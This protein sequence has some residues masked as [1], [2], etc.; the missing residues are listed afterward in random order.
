MT[1]TVNYRSARAPGERLDGGALRRS[2]VSLLCVLGVSCS[3]AAPPDASPDALENAPQRQDESFELPDTGPP[4]FAPGRGPRVGIDEAHHNYHTADGRYRAFAELLQRDGYRV[5]GFAHELT[6]ESL[7]GID[8][9]VISNAVSAE[10]EDDWS[11]PNHPAFSEAEVAAAGA[12]V[13]AGGSL[14]LIADHMPM[15]GATASLARAFGVLFHDGF[16]YNADD[17]GLMTFAKEDGRL[18]EHGVTHDIPAVMTFTGQ[19]FLLAPGTDGEPLMLLEPGSY[20]LLPPVAWE[21]DDSTPRIPAD[22]MIQGA[23]LRHGS[24]RVAVFGEAAAFSAQLG[25]GSSTPMGMNSPDAPYNARFL[26]NVMRWLT[27][28]ENP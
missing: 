25:S 11:L 10:N 16:A 12:W 22:G 26:L 20:V 2:L 13:H 3:G 8:V 1:R 14:M 15:P 7:S 5:A 19:A 21:F 6:A 18:A 28:K 24:G 9:L 17:T 4:E 23:L 27:D